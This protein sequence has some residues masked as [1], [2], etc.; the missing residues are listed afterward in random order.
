MN[1]VAKINKKCISLTDLNRK[2]NMKNDNT[3]QGI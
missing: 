1:L 2:Y 3:T